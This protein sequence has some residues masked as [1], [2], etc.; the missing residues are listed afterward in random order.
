[1]HRQNIQAHQMSTVTTS[2]MAFLDLTFEER[3][4]MMSECR[5]KAWVLGQGEAAT[6]TKTVSTSWGATENEMKIN[7]FVS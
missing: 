7:S 6:G 2:Q 4:V 1:M 5:G 3:D